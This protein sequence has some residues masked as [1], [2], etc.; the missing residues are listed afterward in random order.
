MAE[1][2]RCAAVRRRPTLRESAPRA[3]AM[4][5]RALADNHGTCDEVDLDGEIAVGLWGGRKDEARRT[6][7]AYMMTKM[8]PG[9]IGSD[10]AEQYVRAT[11]AAVGS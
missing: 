4:R 1:I 5:G 10:R 6:T 11:Y 9:I 8:G 2:S 3:R 7:I